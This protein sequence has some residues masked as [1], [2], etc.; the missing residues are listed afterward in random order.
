MER[1]LRESRARVRRSRSKSREAGLKRVEV[2]V[3]EVHAD[4]VRAYAA[5]LRRGDSSD[6]LRQVRKL[7]AK[8][9]REFHASCLDNIQVNPDTANFADAAIVAT[10]LMHRGNAAAF[11]LGRELK[12]LLR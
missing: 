7:I 4:L 12:L 6:T 1:S 11:K 9:Y 10:A 2:L 8:A 5:Q 3:P